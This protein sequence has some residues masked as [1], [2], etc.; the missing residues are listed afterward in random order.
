MDL[1]HLVYDEMLN[2]SN[3][4]MNPPPE[5]LNETRS[6]AGMKLHSILKSLM[7]KNGESARAAAKACK[8]PLSTFTGYLKPDK[9]QIDPGHLLAIAKH[10]GV[11]IDYLFGYQQSMKF[12][13]L[14]TK[15]LFSKWVKLT[16]EDIAD[17][18]DSIDTTKG[19]NK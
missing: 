2:T 10:Y 12:D 19:D 11:S 18:N 9:K 8:I 6:I 3:G 4:F 5:N 7:E 14:P 15:K 1:N 13:K 16:I 17:D